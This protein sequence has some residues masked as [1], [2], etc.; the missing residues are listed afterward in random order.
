MKVPKTAGAVTLT[1]FRNEREKKF[2]AQTFN[3]RKRT[4]I[5]SCFTKWVVE[6]LLRSTRQ[7]SHSTYAF[8][9]LYCRDVKHGAY[10]LDM[11]V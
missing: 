5:L 1:R 2:I 7:L 10:G 6:L 11:P 9:F 3:L 8:M 4:N